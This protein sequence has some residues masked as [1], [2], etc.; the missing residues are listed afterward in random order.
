MSPRVRW[1]LL[2]TFQS[3]PTKIGDA[4][5]AHGDGTGALD[6]YRKSLA[7]RDTLAGRDPPNTQWQVDL[8]VSCSKPGAFSGLERRDFL[9]RGLKILPALR[10]ADRLLPNQDR[11]GWFESALKE[12]DAK[13]PQLAGGFGF[14]RLSPRTLYPRST[15]QKPRI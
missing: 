4:L 10:Q 7:I 2:S 12:L 9:V 1:C 13:A 5:V 8:A 3:S 15:R 14:G 11:T 6:A